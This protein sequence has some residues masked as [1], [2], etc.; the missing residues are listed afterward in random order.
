MTQGNKESRLVAWTF[1]NENQ[2]I[3]WRL[4]Q[5]KA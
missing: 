5:S 1:M 2:R 4:K 3:Q